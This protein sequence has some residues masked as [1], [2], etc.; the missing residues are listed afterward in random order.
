M[1]KGEQAASAEGGAP[2]PDQA[3]G[4]LLAKSA[5]GQ[6]GP[7][8]PG[9]HGGGRERGGKGGARQA[10]CPRDPNA[11]PHKQCGHE[12]LR[13]GVTWSALYLGEQQW[14]RGP[15]RARGT[16]TRTGTSQ[17]D[18][19]LLPWGS[20][21]NGQPVF[22]EEQAPGPASPYE[23]STQRQEEMPLPQEPGE[24]PHCSHAP[25]AECF[26]GRCLIRGPSDSVRRVGKNRLPFECPP[27]AAMSSPPSVAL[28]LLS[29]DLPLGGLA[30]VS[31]TVSSVG[32]R[33][34]CRIRPQR[35][36]EGIQKAP[37]RARCCDK[38]LGS[39]RGSGREKVTREEQ[40]HLRTLDRSA[41]SGAKPRQALL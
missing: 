10:T 6:R 40:Q 22:M 28:C 41:R 4:L 11:I 38:E 3:G 5:A 35:P 30:A 21:G 8:E 17:Q 32:H 14:L 12:G 25:S 26:H 19:M 27:R 13:T 39:G 36:W 20:P 37:T 34:V 7:S 31:R 2:G 24:F 33:S 23:S 15:Q 16:G 29:R 18:T 9:G 1:L